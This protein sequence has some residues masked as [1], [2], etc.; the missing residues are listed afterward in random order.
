MPSRWRQGNEIF[1][2][3]DYS[4]ASDCHNV[5]RGM[6]GNEIYLKQRDVFGYRKWREGNQITLSLAIHKES[7]ETQT[8]GRSNSG[9]CLQQNLLN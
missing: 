6:K 2:G 1:F 4:T 7:I 9:S 5:R 3:E 8:D